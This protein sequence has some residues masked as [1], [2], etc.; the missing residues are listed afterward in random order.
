VPSTARAAPTSSPNAA[1]SVP[2]STVAASP[3]AKR[4]P[5]QQAASQ[6]TGSST[7]SARSTHLTGRRPVRPP[8]GMPHE[9]TTHRRLPGRHHHRVPGHL[10]RH[11]PLASRRR[12]PDRHRIGP[13][14]TDQ[15]R[16][17]QVRALRPG[18]VRHLQPSLA[19]LEAL[20]ASRLPPRVSHLPPAAA[21]G[22]SP[23]EPSPAEPSRTVIAHPTTVAIFSTA[24][25]KISGDVA[26]LIRTR[27]SPPVPKG[28]PEFTATRARL[29][30]TS[31]G[32]SGRFSGRQSSH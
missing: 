12:R 1:P 29:R 16:R 26:M 9:L 25:V 23:A 15:R 19:G 21:R 3:P 27:P 6:P 30:N 2:R 5:P 20:T 4:S 10:H 24:S 7:P 11:L 22:S 32:S 18:G 28:M 17:G 31:E 8:R 13:Q 14:H